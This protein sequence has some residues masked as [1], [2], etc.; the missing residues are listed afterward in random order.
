MLHLDSSARTA[1]LTVGSELAWLALADNMT[2][3]VSVYVF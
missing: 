2:L 3:S 1:F